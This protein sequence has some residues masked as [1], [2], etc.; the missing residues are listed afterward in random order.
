MIALG[1]FYV[2]S[3]FRLC[4]ASD[5][6]QTRLGALG[7]LGAL[8]LLRPSVLTLDLYDP[9]NMFGEIRIVTQFCY[10][11]TDVWHMVHHDHG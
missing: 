7:F 4:L 2:L 8:Q 11:I 9:K 6:H 5:V 3:D 10:D 1:N